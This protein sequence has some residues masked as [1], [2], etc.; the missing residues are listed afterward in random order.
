MA[1]FSLY[2]RVFMHVDAF[3]FD[4]P[5]SAIALRPASP[6]D[7]AKLLQVHPNGELS[8]HIVSALPDFL[9]A[10]DVL[11]LNDTRVLRAALSGVRPAR[12]VGG[13]DRD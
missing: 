13:G 1:G 7:S 10:G 9:R 12:A 5:E 11:V 6:R 3:D 4:L 8:D 2:R